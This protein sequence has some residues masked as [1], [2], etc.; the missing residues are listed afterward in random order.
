MSWTT[1]E[2]DRS[3]SPSSAA[4]ETSALNIDFGG[5]GEENLALRDIILSRIHEAGPIPF[6]EFM[7]LAL[8][9]PLHGYYVRNDPTRDYQSS[10]NVHPVFGAAI[11]RHL[12]D[13][14]QLLDRPNRFDVVEAG[15]NNGRLAADVLRAMRQ[16]APDCYDATRYFLQDQALETSDTERVERAGVPLDKATILEALPEEAS[17]TGVI[18]SNELLDAFPCERVRVRDGHLFEVRVGAA[19]ERF[20]DVEAPV[21]EEIV[22]YFG[23]LGLR[24]GEGCEAEVNL[25]APR[26]ITRASGAL[27]R[28]YVLTLDYGYEAKDLYA[29]WR[30]QGTLLT[31]YRH[32]SGSDPYIRIGEQDITASVDFTT[33]RRTGEAA[34][35]RTI[36][37]ATQASFLA[38]LGIGDTLTGPRDRGEIE[39]YYALRKAVIELTDGSGLG[40][41][42]VLSQGKDVPDARPLGLE[43]LTNE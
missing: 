16:T 24:P 37:G 20:V 4:D 29:P 40:R 36:G 1:R 17:I 41:V 38:A 31:F 21:A 42:R 22:G 39:A 18:F 26:W 28:G 5:G 23:A 2:F 6:S 3:S 34:G 15:A 12:T 9:H 13:C 19:G 27:T 10:P 8:Y 35:L 7:R 14:W 33:L 30:R 11:A 32:T 25:E 43:G